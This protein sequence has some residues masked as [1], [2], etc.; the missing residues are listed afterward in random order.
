MS[1]VGYPK[2]PSLKT[3]SGCSLSHFLLFPSS[4]DDCSSEALS[5]LPHFVNI[6]VELAHGSPGPLP[7]MSW[8]SRCLL[9]GSLFAFSQKVDSSVCSGGSPQ[10]GRHMS[11]LLLGRKRDPGDLWVPVPY[12]SEECLGI[13]WQI[14]VWPSFP[15]SALC[16]C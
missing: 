5:L 13:C 10:E 1:D 8:G 15:I 7:L 4:F 16:S 12:C 9:P 3:G 14:S 6:P 2:T 11:C